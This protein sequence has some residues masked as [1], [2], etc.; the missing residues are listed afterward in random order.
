MNT[1]VY[2]LEARGFESESWINTR[3]SF[4][5]ELTSEW[6]RSLKTIDNDAVE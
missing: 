2:R 3:I 6:E 4:P 5:N 1:S